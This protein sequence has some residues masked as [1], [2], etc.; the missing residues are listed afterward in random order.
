MV[1]LQGPTKREKL[2]RRNGETRK[3]ADDAATAGERCG[4]S[5]AITRGVKK[6]EERKRESISK[7]GGRSAT[8]ES[9]L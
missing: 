7:L 4:G 9:G 8:Q 3:K 6:R 5:A 1:K 2:L